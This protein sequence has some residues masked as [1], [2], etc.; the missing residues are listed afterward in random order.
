MQKAC[1]RIARQPELNLFV[2]AFLLNLPWEL[3]QIPLFREMPS[4]PHVVGVVRCLRAAAGD[5]L[6]LLLAFWTIAWITGSRR[7]LFHLSP[8]RLGGFIAVGL[9][10]TIAMEYW[11][12]VVAERWDY[13]DA[14]PRL[15]LLGTGLAPLL[16]WILIPPL[17]LWLTQRQL[18]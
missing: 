14:M 5:G 18:K 8:V 15:P 10:I 3:V 2:F 4:L 11:A 13:A 9:A 16:Q 12:T 17:A 1:T 7:W 6:I